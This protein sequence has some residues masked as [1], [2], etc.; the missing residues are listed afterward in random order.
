MKIQF[1]SFAECRNGPAKLK[2][3]V[4]P[5]SQFR[6]GYL[7]LR[8]CGT[9]GLIFNCTRRRVENRLVRYFEGL[10]MKSVTRDAL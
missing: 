2:T 10:S 5:V 1:R 7:T 3:H 9:N 6:R 8:N 4:F